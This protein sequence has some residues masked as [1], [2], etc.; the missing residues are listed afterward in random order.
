MSTPTATVPC[1]AHGA[2]VEKTS[3]I[4][5]QKLLVQRVGWLTALARD[6]TA[7]LVTARWTAADL[8]ALASG[9][10][11]PAWPVPLAAPG[12]PDRP[13]AGGLQACARPS[14]R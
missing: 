6:L 13:V 2:T 12:G 3:E 7:R 10:G 9:V 4:V 1:T 8:D 14:P 11:H 5:S